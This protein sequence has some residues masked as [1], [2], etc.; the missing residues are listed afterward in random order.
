MREWTVYSTRQRAEVLAVVFL[1]SYV[2][3]VVVGVLA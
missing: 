2:D 1:G 3:I